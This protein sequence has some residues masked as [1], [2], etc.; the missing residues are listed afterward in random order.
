MSF[1]SPLKQRGIALIMAMLVVAIATVTAV[2]L[3]HEQ[4]FSVRKTS[5]LQHYDTGLLY[6]VGLEDYA[7]LFLKK[8]AKD[9]KI[10]HLGEDWAIG[11]P[12]LP[13]EEGFL[14]G[15]IQD[16]QGLLNINNLLTNAASRQQLIRLCKNQDVD[17]DFVPALIDW[18][19]QNTQAEIPDG[20]EDD[21]YTAL[22]IPYRTANRLMADISELKL[23]KGVNDEMYM[24]LKP[25]LTALP[26]ETALNLN[27]I[28][29]EIFDTLGLGQTSQQFIDERDKDAFKNLNDFET[30]MNIPLDE[31][32]K[33][34]LSVST[35]YFLA[36]GV[37]TI[38]EKS[39]TLNSLINRDPKNGQS[40]VITRSLGSI[41]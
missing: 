14:S 17:S 20:A 19:D 18:I 35:S 4:S 11:I 37:V 33:A 32:Q 8:D 25:F 38:G 36:S 6:A 26:E 7:R 2:S 3:V 34:Y 40:K 31:N 1:S 27:T 10:D 13:I 41:L 21:Y 9:S 39:I 23:I 16:A 29:G 22:E 30:R 28:P 24:K 12:A 5:N 15:S